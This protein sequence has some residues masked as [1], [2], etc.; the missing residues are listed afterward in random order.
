MLFDSSALIFS[1]LASVIAKWDSTPS[2][3][4]GFGRVE[5][6][7]GFLNCAALFV[8]SASIVVEAVERLITPQEIQTDNLLLV[9]VLGFI[10]NILGI[11][12]F[13]HGGMGHDHSHGD[14]DHGHSHDHSHDHGSHKSTGN[15]LMH[16]MF[17]HILADTLGSA[18]VIISTLCIQYFGWTWSDPVCSLFL[19]ALIFMSIWPLFTRSGGALLQQTP[20]VVQDKI[21]RIYQEV[22]SLPE[23]VSVLDTHFW[24]QAS[25]QYVGTM[26][27]V[28]RS[29][30]V[31]QQV[32]QRINDIVLNLV[33]GVRWLT[34]QI[35]KDQMMLQQ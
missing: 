5:I 10:V 2:F 14:H 11:I 17:L 7:A 6:L 25:E 12:A 19:A 22:V 35:D 9:A 33:P 21:S 20:S 13:D 30:S 8:A 16:G 4:Y 29:D 18:G 15:I 3:S 32:R 34:I 31:D 23:V 27:V 26:R 28:V 24:E 1:L